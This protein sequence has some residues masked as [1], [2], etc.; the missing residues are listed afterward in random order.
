MSGTLLGLSDGA[1]MGVLDT[2]LGRRFQEFKKQQQTPCFT[3]PGVRARV[4]VAFPLK[5]LI[6]LG[7]ILQVDSRGARPFLQPPLKPS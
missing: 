1:D 6:G 2:R 7:R 5:G 3:G 4:V